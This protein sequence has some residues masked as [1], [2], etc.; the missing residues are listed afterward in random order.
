MGKISSYHLL[1]PAI[2][3]DLVEPKLELAFHFGP[4]T[5]VTPV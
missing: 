4:I 2:F 1:I 3:V 5:V